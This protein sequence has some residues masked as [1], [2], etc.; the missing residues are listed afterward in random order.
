MEFVFYAPMV[1]PKF[2]QVFSGGFF[3]GKTCDTI[4]GLMCDFCRLDVVSLDV[5]FV[6]LCESGPI[7]IGSQQDATSQGS[8]GDKPVC[9]FN[10]GVCVKMSICLGVEVFKPQ[11]MLFPGGLSSERGKEVILN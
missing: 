11:G 2:E 1:P 6:D 9:G 4:L 10:V 8:G 7:G 5:I 3:R